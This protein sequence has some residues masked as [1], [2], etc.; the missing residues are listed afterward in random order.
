M[1][2][3]IDKPKDRKFDV[4][5]IHHGLFDNPDGFGV[6]YA[7]NNTVH[8]IKSIVSKQLL[9]LLDTLQDKDCIVHLRYKTHGLVSHDNCHP[10]QVTDDI[11]MMHN[12]VI[13]TANIDDAMSDSFNFAR[14]VLSPILSANPC[15]FGTVQFEK[16]VRG[17]IGDSNKIILLR[18][19]GIKQ[20]I[21][22][23]VIHDGIWYSNNSALPVAVY[24]PQVG[25]CKY[26]DNDDNTKY[27]LYTDVY[28]DVSPRTEIED[29]EQLMALRRDEIIDFVAQY[30]EDTV[31]MLENLFGMQ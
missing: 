13:Q 10:Y 17:M 26:Y 4:S 15:L 5:I 19:D 11:Y 31:D 9:P 25:A 27:M 24:T 12:G 20:T 28:D 3:I 2:L 22:N 23:G 7:E 1:C 29:I 18:A 16:M 21:G 8:V 6:M 14:Y 30:P